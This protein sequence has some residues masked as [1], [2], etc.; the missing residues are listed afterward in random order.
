[1]KV[2]YLY[3]NYF[4]DSPM[5]ALLLKLYVAQVL[6]NPRITC[7]TLKWTKH[8]KQKAEPDWIKKQETTE[9][10]KVHKRGALNKSKNQD[11]K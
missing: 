1:M 9:K 4:C 10:L 7:T 8:S 11:S 6:Y 2:R 5:T 3:I